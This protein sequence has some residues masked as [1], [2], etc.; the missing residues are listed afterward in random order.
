MAKPLFAPGPGEAA[1]PERPKQFPDQKTCR[2]KRSDF[3][4]IYDCF[5]WWSFNCPSQLHFGGRKLCRHPNVQEIANWK[6]EPPE[7]ASK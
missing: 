2:V 1:S 7:V 5:N 4:E 3:A 6:D